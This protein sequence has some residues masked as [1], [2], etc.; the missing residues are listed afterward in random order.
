M[1]RDF[2]FISPNNFYFLFHATLIFFLTKNRLH[3]LKFAEISSFY[4][5]FSLYVRDFPF[6]SGYYKK[7]KINYSET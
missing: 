6:L 7:M 1:K 2:P 3:E 4:P 5:A